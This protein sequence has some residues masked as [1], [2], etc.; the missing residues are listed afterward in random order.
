MLFLVN[1]LADWGAI[2]ARGT[3]VQRRNLLHDQLWVFNTSKFIHVELVRQLHD[4][5]INRP[6]LIER[7]GID[8]VAATSWPDSKLKVILAN[9]ALL[10]N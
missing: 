2:L 6:G 8:D 5:T 9:C 10:N 4:T 7:N 3:L 1:Q